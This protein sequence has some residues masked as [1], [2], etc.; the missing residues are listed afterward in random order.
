MIYVFYNNDPLAADQGGGAEHFRAL[1]RALLVS[2]LPFRLVA[3]RLQDEREAPQVEYVSRG[4]GFLRFWLGCWRWFW[5]NRHHLREDDVFHFHR[6]YAAWPKYVLAPRRGRVVLTYHVVTGQVLAGALGPLARPVRRVMLFFERRAVR[7]A[8]V[9]VCVSE[10]IRE[11]LARTVDPAFARALVLPAG[12]DDSLFRARPPRPPAPQQA[13]RLLFVG[14]ISH[15]KNVPLA[16]AVLEEL[17]RRGHTGFTLTIAGQGE[18]ARDLL[19]RIDRSPART[20][21]RWLGRVPHDRMPELYAA[22]GIVL[23]TSRAEA[24]PTVVKEALAALRPVVTTDVGDVRLWVEEGETG[25]VRPA[26]A[27]ALAD[28]VLEAARLVREGRIRPSRKLAA[29]GERDFMAPVLELYR[30]LRAS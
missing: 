10:R 9:L 29:L 20:A 21:I 16:V 14:R 22:H 4:A 25:F 8:D 30:G 27:G 17:Y 15:V 24:S 1:H 26:E 13:Q 18:G 5:K 19:R 28:A 11:E 12:F 7:R 2:G 23:V 3:A 6:N